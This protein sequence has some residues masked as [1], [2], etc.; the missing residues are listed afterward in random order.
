MGVAPVAEQIPV[1]GTLSP[2]F[3]ISLLAVPFLLVFR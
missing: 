2:R 1:V 3:S